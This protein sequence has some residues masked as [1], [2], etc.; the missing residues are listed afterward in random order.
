M[1]NF[2]IKLGQI[3]KFCDLGERS[4]VSHWFCHLEGLNEKNSLHV[5][6]ERVGIGQEASIFK[7]AAAAILDFFSTSLRSKHEQPLAT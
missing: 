3:H 2:H 4:K 1:C 6:R 7:M 5:L